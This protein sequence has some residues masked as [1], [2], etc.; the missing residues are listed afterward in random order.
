MI[1]GG[2]RKLEDFTELVGADMHITINWAG[3][4]DKLIELDKDVASR[5]D[6]NLNQEQI[7][8]LGRELPDYDRALQV[9]GMTV[10]EYFD[11]GG[12]ELFRTS[13]QK[14]WDELLAY[15]GE[16]RKAYEAKN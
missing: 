8:R 14:G 3:T 1:G 13:F 5:I 6:F 2:A 12:V 4:A 9:D 11:Y 16:R 15:I 7:D 10:D